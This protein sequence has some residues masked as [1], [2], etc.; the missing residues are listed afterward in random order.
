ME[1]VISID[2]EVH[3]GTM[4]T[5]KVQRSNREGILNGVLNFGF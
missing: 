5:P 2:D 1:E 4:P 3:L